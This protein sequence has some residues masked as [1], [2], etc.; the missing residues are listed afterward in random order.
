ML[1]MISFTELDGFWGQVR[2]VTGVPQQWRVTQAENHIELRRACQWPHTHLG[3][4]FRQN[5]AAGLGIWP[6]SGFS[7]N[8]ANRTFGA[9]CG[10]LLPDAV[11]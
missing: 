8:L 4:P 2:C 11:F 1:V 5:A 9:Q 6:H 10:R 7:E 3:Q